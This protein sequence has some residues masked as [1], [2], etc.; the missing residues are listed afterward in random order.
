MDYGFEGS[1]ATHEYD[2]SEQNFNEFLSVLDSTYGLSDELGGDPEDT[3][4]S[5]LVKLSWN[6]AEDHRADF[7]YQWQ[8]DAD[9]RNYGTGGDTVMLASSRYTYETKFNNFAAKLYSDWSGNLD[10]VVLPIKMSVATTAT[11][12]LVAL[13]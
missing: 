1:G 4:D 11:Q 7:T 13:R 10:R 3:N 8:D 5:L 2:T 6:V 12:A 9:E